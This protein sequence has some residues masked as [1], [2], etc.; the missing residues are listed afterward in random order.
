MALFPVVAAGVLR[1]ALQPE[2]LRETLEYTTKNTAAKTG[3][4]RGRGEGGRE[5]CLTCMRPANMTQTDMSL[6][7]MRSSSG[8]V[9]MQSFMQLSRKLVWCHS[10]SSM[11]DA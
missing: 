11:L 10:T 8:L 4:G 2:G 5:A 9:S 1:E 6:E 7:K 3:R